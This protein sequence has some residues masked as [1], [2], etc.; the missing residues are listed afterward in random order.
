MLVF[1]HHFYPLTTKVDKGILKLVKALR[2]AHSVN[3]FLLKE[4]C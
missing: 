3:F 4:E 2:L 1:N